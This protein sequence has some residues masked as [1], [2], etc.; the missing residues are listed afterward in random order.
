M[1]T[2][3]AILMAVIATFGAV[4]A[5]RAVT[6]EEDTSA[7][8]RRLKQGQVLELSRRAELLNTY[9][10]LAQFQKSEDLARLRGFYLRHKAENL[11]KGD[12]TNPSAGS[13]LDV[14]AEEQ[15]A[16]ARMYRR[17]SDFSYIY[18]ADKDSIETGI[19]KIVASDLSALGYGAVWTEPKKG[20]LPFIWG[21]LQS[22]VDVN[23]KKTVRL[24]G[25]VALFVLA[26]AFLTFTQLS[27]EASRLQ[28]WLERI[29][30]IIAVGASIVSVVVF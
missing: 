9:R 25:L 10:E 15:F 8:E 6:A 7:W 28:R 16:I 29:A 23:R 17:I 5:Y 19:E 12:L 27:A 20:E 18:I 30:Y 26:L 1:R 24:S 3:V 14:Q 13:E 21:G 4:V 11:R 22:Q 2:R